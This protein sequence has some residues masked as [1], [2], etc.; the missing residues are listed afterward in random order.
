MKEN[1]LVFCAHSD[2]Q[3]LGPGGTIAKYA[4]EGLNVHT[5]I[6]SYQDAL[7][8]HLKDRIIKNERI[9]ESEAADKVIG[10]KGVEFFGLGDG[11]LNVDA[12]KDSTHKNL[13]KLIKKFKPT[14][15]FTHSDFDPHPDHRAVHRAIIKAVEDSKLNIEV[16]T[17]EIWTLLRRKTLESPKMVVDISDTFKIKADA[18]N[19]FKS[20]WHAMLLLKWSIYVKAI[21]S[22][23][24]NDV[25]F[26]EV[27]NRVK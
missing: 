4:K 19:C 6:F 15:I 20:Q 22:G 11:K 3:V 1:I 13:L 7:R 27:F 14:K 24:K 21:M 12:A 8:L 23:F 17:F 16:Y 2:D 26:A 25:K 10:G 18:L 5:F 9:K